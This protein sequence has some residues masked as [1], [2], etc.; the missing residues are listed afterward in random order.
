MMIRKINAAVLFIQDLDKCM[1]FYRDTL[2]FKFTF[3]DDVSFAFQLEGQD[4]VVLTIP[5]AVDMLGEE[6]ISSGKEAVHRVMLCCEVEGVDAV[7]TTLMAKGVTFIRP[8]KDQ[9]WGRRTAHFADPEGN[10]WE[11]YEHLEPEQ[12]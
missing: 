4:F 6:A 1:K 9:A 10:I 3:N 12:K 11:M 2:G 8:P 7:Y 5:A